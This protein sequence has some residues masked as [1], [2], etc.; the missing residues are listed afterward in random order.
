MKND[1]NDEMDHIIQLYFENLESK[2]KEV[3]YEV[4]KNL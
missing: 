3:Q 2:D 1:D 4:Y